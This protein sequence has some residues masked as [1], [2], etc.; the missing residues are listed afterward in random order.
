MAGP[1]NTGDTSF[2]RGY[3]NGNLSWA[4]TT[5]PGDR[6]FALHEV[7]EPTGLALAGVGLLAAFMRPKRRKA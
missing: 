2:Q 1:Y 3:T 5:R 6:A 4:G 7:P